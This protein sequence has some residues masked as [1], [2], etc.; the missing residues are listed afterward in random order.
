[1]TP[2]RL[3]DL[4]P[5]DRNNEMGQDMTMMMMLSDAEYTDER[6]DEQTW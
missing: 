4:G 3:L 1:V 5:S 6:L 2:T